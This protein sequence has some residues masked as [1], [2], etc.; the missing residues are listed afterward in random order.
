MMSKHGIKCQSRKFNRSKSE[1][2]K[3]KKINLLCSTKKNVA[4]FM[5]SYDHCN[6][7]FVT[8]DCNSS[9]LPL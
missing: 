4:K 8:K 5:A 1:E 3:Y 6:K 7:S 9:L 2:N